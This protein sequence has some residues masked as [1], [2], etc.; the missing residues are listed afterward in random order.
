VVRRLIV[1]D[2]PSRPREFIPEGDVLE[3]GRSLEVDLVLPDRSVSRHHAVLRRRG[4]E[5]VVED[6]GS[7]FGTFVNGRPLR[8][9]IPLALEDGDVIQCGQVRVICRFEEERAT[10]AEALRDASFAARANARILLLEDGLVRRE[11][12]ARA[13]TLIGCSV[14][15]DVRLCDGSGPLEQARI[16]ASAERFVLEPRGTEPPLLDEAQTPV[17]EPADLP[18]SSAVVLRGGQMLF[19]YDF[20]A[21]DVPV[22]DPLRDLGR[23][24]LLR[25][26][27]RWTG[28]P[29]RDLARLAGRRRRIGQE[30]GEILVERGLLTPLT[31]IV[32]RSRI[33]RAGGGT[34]W[35][36]PS[37]SGA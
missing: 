22:A 31:W 19:L 5:L 8:S 10:P 27:A 17:V 25:L 36:R 20:A 6:A 26:A 18:S 35:S 1:L 33:I 7:T 34:W 23:R 12:I 15:C 37:P 4:G 2:G 16:R 9:G 14:H 28:I 24:R 13:A 11:P 29:R 3:I 21:G 30:L 32:I